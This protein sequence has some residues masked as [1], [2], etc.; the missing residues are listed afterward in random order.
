MPAVPWMSSVEVPEMAAARCSLSQL[1]AVPGTPYSSKA[2]SV[3]SVA[4]AIS[5]SRSLPTYLGV[6]TKPLSSVPPST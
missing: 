4:M 1:L 3:A 5:T 2:R 6:T